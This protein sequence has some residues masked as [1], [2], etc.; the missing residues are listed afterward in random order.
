MTRIISRAIRYCTCFV[1][2][3]M[4]VVYSGGQYFKVSASTQDTSTRD[5]AYWPF[6]AN[7]PWNMPIGSEAKFEPMSSPEWTTAQKYGF[8]INSTEYTIPVYVATGSDPVRKV[9]RT[10][11]VINFN[12]PFEQRV[13]DAAA[14]SPGSDAQ[15]SLI[16]ET[17]NYVTEM[18]WAKRRSDGG[19]EAPFPNK[20]DLRG[21]GVFKDY[22]GSCA[23]G[24][25]CT[26][27][28][29]RKGELKN[30]IRHA[31]RIA[32]TPTVV[33]KNAPG[34]KPYVWPA[35]SADDGD[36]R[37]YTGTGNMYM[38][39]LLAI[40]PN[41]NIQEIA[42]PPGTPL[43]ELAKALQDY[44][45]YVADTGYLNLYAEPTAND[46]VQT[47]LYNTTVPKY[48]QVVVNNGSDRVGGGGTPRRPLAPPFP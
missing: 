17:H 20:I 28:L 4:L 45:A 38:G 12:A 9:Y 10:D 16:D 48:L 40:P 47:L 43:Y 19:I 23:Y 11:S 39:S 42:G 32:I 7:S 8:I 25:S 35:S 2:A 24:G 14:P 5:P 41:V 30:G 6:D 1:L 3:A 29:I 36:G 31:L 46:E 26:A 37:S 27:G 13:P 18:I 44:G 15:L 21:P 33:N 22:H 34:G